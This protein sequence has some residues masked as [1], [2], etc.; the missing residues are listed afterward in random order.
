MMGRGDPYREP[1]GGYTHPQRAKMTFLNLVGNLSNNPKKGWTC[2]FEWDLKV[3]YGMDP[4]NTPAETLFK[5]LGD[6]HLGYRIAMNCG[7]MGQTAGYWG[8]AV[9]NGIMPF[10]PHYNN[11]GGY[12]FDDPIGIRAAVSVAGGTRNNATTYGPSLEFID[13]VPESG[14]NPKREDTAQSWANQ[15][16]AA[17]FSRILDAHPEYNI[18]D[19]REHLRQ[20]AS[21]WTNGWTEA[22]G[23]GRVNER[24]TVA[25]LLPGPPVEFMA[26]KSRDR[27]QVTFKWR[28]FLMTGF[29]A[30]VIAR[31]D[32]RLV[33]EGRGTNFVWNSDLDGD[34]TFRYWSRNQSGEI[35]RMET[36]QTRTIKGL[37][38][39]AYQTCVAFGSP[40][41]D[42]SITRKLTDRFQQVATN[43]VCDVV[44]QKGNSFYDHLTTPLDGV[45]AAVLPDR[46]AMVDYAISNHYRV[47]MAPIGISEKEPYQ[48]KREWD[49]AVAAS[50]LV[51]VPHHASYSTSRKP[52]A[53]RLA[54]PRLFSAITVGLGETTN[55]LTFGPGLEF[56]D[57][58]TMPEAVSFGLTN[59]ADAAG[60]VAG[61][62]AQI[63]DAH[64]EYNI[65]DA[66]QHLRQSS[67]NYGTG[68][69]E[70][71]G[72]GRPPSTPAKINRLDLAPPLEIQGA[73][74]PGG[75]SIMFEW[76]NFLQT[77]FAETV[78]TR[79]DGQVIY[80]GTGTNFVW[81]GD[82]NENESFHF[83]SQD[84]TGRRSKAE[85][86]TVLN[87]KDLSHDQPPAAPRVE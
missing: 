74:S 58:P 33:Y 37:N 68:W 69:I 49:R 43:W 82:A 35:S 40:A 71:G 22:N 26:V 1:N 5:Y 85:S 65:W 79:G 76:Q 61:K 12:R 38:C 6:H 13:A 64:P 81:Q 52:E 18:W 73:K 34:E 44:F 36:Y 7:P 23:Y 20:A 45:A 57:N 54:P 31:N 62:L 72:Y 46:S 24:T 17:R 47:L 16:V 67:S 66:R 10:G 78:I 15:A 87:A 48:F 84:K 30:T 83:F 60:I 27:H 53:R 8:A 39:G 56:F 42:E 4:T 80:H 55:K 77:A 11:V 29:A 21:Y 3:K 63:L 75:N 32:G 51:V 41:T 19:A 28:N 14:P 50:V 86:Y 25:K 70:D 2:E 9:D 59:Q